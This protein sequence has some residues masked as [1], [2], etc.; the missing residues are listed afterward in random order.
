MKLPHY[1]AD[2]ASEGFQRLEDLATAYWYSEVLFTALELSI[3]GLLGEGS[4]S[5]DELARTSGY[6]ADGL[7]RFLAA[8]VALGLIVEHDGQFANGPLAAHYLIPGTDSYMGDFLLYRRFLTSHWQRLGARIRQGSTANDRSLEETPEGYRKRTLAYVRAM[9]L[10]ARIKAAEAL[11][12]LGKVF[13]T[14]PAQVLDVGGGAGAWCRALRS[15]WPNVRM[16]LL[17]LPE[18]LAAARQLYP[19]EKSW[20]G[21]EVLAGNILTPCFRR[22]QFDLVLLSNVLH[23]YGESEAQAILKYSAGCLAPGGMVLIHDYLADLHDA[24]PVKGTFYDLHMLINTYN[25]RI[26]RLAELVALLEGAGLQHVRLRHLRTDTSI[27]L[28]NP[29][30]PKALE[31]ISQHEM[32]TAQAQQLGFASAHVIKTSEIV[33]EPWVRLKCQFGC[34]HY[35]QSPGCPPYALDEGKMATTISRYKHALLVQGTPP[36]K[37]FHEQ[38]LALEKALFLGGHTE[39]LAFGAGPCPVCPSCVTD[40]RC[41]FPEKLRP[42]LEA[43]GVD[44]Y[45]TARRADLNLNPVQHHLGYVKY[46]GLVLFDVKENY[47]GPADPGNFNA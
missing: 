17:D 27:L 15:L 41:R 35:D 33:V 40:G 5:I 36:S 3:F 19:E 44:V 13:G 32:L 29:E 39:A 28:A 21:I 9:D 11:D 24:D 20:K 2:I 25:G 7:N 10:Q 45:K 8:L 38:L 23:A 47:E 30:G 6:E 43:C 37:I 1:N 4:A 42:S 31:H 26:Y 18:T 34:S 14:P 22:P 12:F 46:V 16:V